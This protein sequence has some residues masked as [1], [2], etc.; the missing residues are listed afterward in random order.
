MGVIPPGPRVA[1]GQRFN[2]L[3]RNV[4]DHDTQRILRNFQRSAV[5]EPVIET[6]IFYGGKRR[7]EEKVLRQQ[8]NEECNP[9]ADAQLDIE[10]ARALLLMR[11]MRLWVR[12]LLAHVED[13][14]D[15]VSERPSLRAASLLHR[16]WRS[17]LF[18]VFSFK[19]GRLETISQHQ[20]RNDIGGR[21][22][23]G[24]EVQIAD[25]ADLLLDLIFCVKIE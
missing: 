2:R 6:G 7:A 23:I 15:G 25:N 10:I 12:S 18:P 19:T 20:T 5:L 22:V 21:S 13:L 1:S 4:H 16:R 3:F 11:C 24:K 9:G 14:C 17:M 8:N